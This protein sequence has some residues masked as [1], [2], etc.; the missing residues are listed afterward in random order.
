MSNREILANVVEILHRVGKVPAATHVT[1]ETRLVEDLAI[2]SLDLVAVFLAVQDHFEI[3]LDDESVPEIRRVRD[4]A[5]RIQEQVS[6]VA[7]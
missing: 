5:A 3:V 6:G 2:D 4:L 1:P 7:A